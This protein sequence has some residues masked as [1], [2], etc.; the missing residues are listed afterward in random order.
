MP[1]EIHEVYGVDASAT[2]L[3]RTMNRLRDFGGSYRGTKGLSLAAYEKCNRR[4]IEAVIAAPDRFVFSD[5]CY[6]DLLDLTRAP[7]IFRNFAT[8]LLFS[9]LFSGMGH[10]M[11]DSAHLTEPEIN[12]RLIERL[13]WHVIGLRWAVE[14]D[15]VVL[16]PSASAFSASVVSNEPLL[17]ADFGLV[18]H[19]RVGE[20]DRYVVALIQ[21]KKMTTAGG[22]ARVD[23][24]DNSHLQLDV[25]TSSGMGH[26]LFYQVGSTG[27]S[28]PYVPATLRP[29]T[30]VWD[31]VAI[32]GAENTTLSKFNVG[33]FGRYTHKELF[34]VDFGAGS[35][36]DFGLFSASLPRGMIKAGVRV[37]SDPEA[38]LITL[39]DLY[40]VERML[41]VT[42][43][44]GPGF[45]S[46]VKACKGRA[47]S[48][49]DSDYYKA[50]AASKAAMRAKS[51]TKK[52]DRSG[53]P[54]PGSGKGG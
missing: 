33:T 38:A 50:L 28:H 32:I 54:K 44:D 26:Y 45:A 19:S 11:A 9:G 48:V 42:A 47:L 2:H 17:G 24:P 15:G 14:N 20:R 35:S 7:W 18:A 43:Q 5:D 39:L 51:P 49:R 12:E 40:N 30:E 36:L 52:S 6:Q 31:E 10:L 1:K 27:S 21:G 23:R 4:A 25:L 3:A 37:F 29:A 16:G 8:G 34:G 53:D 13:A 22:T 46:L 41:A